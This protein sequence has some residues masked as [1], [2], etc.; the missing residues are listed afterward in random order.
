MPSRSG[1]SSSPRRSGSGDSP[2]CP[3]ELGGLVTVLYASFHSDGG[4]E[5][6]DVGKTDKVGRRDGRV[7]GTTVGMALSSLLGRPDGI[8]DGTMLGI[9]EGRAVGRNDGREVGA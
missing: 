1:G 6:V 7:V 3:D 4:D 5:G 8:M 9:E 2:L